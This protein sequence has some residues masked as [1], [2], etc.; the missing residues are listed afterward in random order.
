MPSRTSSTSSAYDRFQ[1]GVQRW[2]RRKEW[3][4]LHGIQERAAG[5]ILQGDRD[6]VI[7][8]ATAG[9]K[10]EAA[11]LPI[12]SRVAEEWEE[13]DVG[14]L[15]VLYVSP[16]KAL[17][18]DQFDRL[19]DL[20]EPL[21]VPVFR[22]HGDVSSS[23]KKRARQEGGLLLITPESLE[24]QFIRRGYA[25]SEF[26]APLR[27]VV[28]DELH[29][30]IGG[31][32]GRQ[33][34]SLL[35]RVDLS[36]RR[37]I[38]RIALSATLGDMEKASAFLRPGKGEN[39]KHISDEGETQT[40]KLQVRGYEHDSAESAPE[41]EAEE[42]EDEEPERPQVSGDLVDIAGNLFDTLRGGRHITFANRRQTVETTA[43]LLR[44][45]CDKAGVPNEFLPHHGSLSRDLRDQAEQ[46]LRNGNRPTTI[47]A[48]TTL[49]LGIDVGNVESI[50]QVGPPPSVASM[51][52]R[53]GRSGRRGDPAV[54]RVYV[55]EAKLDSESPPTD[56]LRIGLVR[57][58]AM[59]RLLAEGWNEPPVTGALHL[60]TLVQQILSMIAQ[61][62]GLDAQQGYDVLCKRGPFRT[63][64]SDQFAT[65]LRD[66][67]AA[68]LITQTH[69]GTLVLDLDGEQLVN[70][71]EFYA[72][73]STPDEYRLVTGG[74]GIGS[75]P[76]V[77]PL[78]EGRYL[79]FGGKRWKVIDVDQEKQVVELVPSEGG[80][81]P[82]FGGMGAMVHG[83]I[84]REMRRVYEA[85]DEPRFVD[86]TGHELL[87]EGRRSF[88]EMGLNEK[89]F[90][91]E[92]T[93]AVWFPWIGDRALNTMEL[94]L[95]REGFD[96]ETQD[97]LLRANDAT[98]TELRDEIQRLRD[99][100]LGDPRALASHAQNKRLEKHHAY[101]SDKLLAADYAAQYLDCDVERFLN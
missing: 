81:A 63:V 31:E 11:F 30:F 55:R 50:A 22:W 23:R 12:A 44:R 94:A 71:Y 80:R 66:L 42:N 37:R 5:P 83:K 43:D 65:L 98:V 54:L 20:F 26:L 1:P 74:S 35:H 49:E 92:G 27:Y 19:R 3:G 15:S 46:R 8:A 10:T 101:L 69:D 57:T 47:V 76:I 85:D 90:V 62:G 86:P 38:P 70:H 96:V 18:N 58:I 24:A 89:S 60:S 73:F 53:L 51:R 88:R 75:L 7:A 25:M 93:N 48:T 14:G 87:D 61:R 99:A 17:I 39:A 91:Q 41:G 79:I 45:R 28:I 95:Q 56:K 64:S 32:R 33:L 78:Y 100:G 40:V 77:A 2:I 6:V 4:E 97:V 21:H 34:Q 29:A 84:R 52:Q 68:N 72:A 82:L 13:E 67:G 36:A 16:L 59:V 9:G